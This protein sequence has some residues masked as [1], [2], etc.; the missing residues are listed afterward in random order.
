MKVKKFLYIIQKSTKLRKVLPSKP[1]FMI[2]FQDFSEG[3]QL[4]K[5]SLN[6]DSKTIICIP[7]STRTWKVCLLLSIFKPRLSHF[8]HRLSL[9]YNKHMWLFKVSVHFVSLVGQHYVV[10]FY[11]FVNCLE[12]FFCIFFVSC[13]DFLVFC[14]LNYLTYE[15]TATCSNLY[16]TENS[17]I[18]LCLY[19]QLLCC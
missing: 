4:E 13:F 1:F 6:I 14:A 18:W 2:A 5:S 17:C 16:S 8:I 10:V 19:C 3:K 11:D 15:L 9:H 12:Y 7:C